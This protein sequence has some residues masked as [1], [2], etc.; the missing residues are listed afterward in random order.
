MKLQGKAAFVPGCT[1]SIGC[2]AA[3]GFAAKTASAKYVIE[4]S[5]NHQFLIQGKNEEQDL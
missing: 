3:P 2:A 5:I 1:V 4:A